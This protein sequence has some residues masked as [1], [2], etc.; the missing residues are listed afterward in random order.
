MKFVKKLK[1][2]V[3]VILNNQLLKLISILFLLD[4]WCILKAHQWSNPYNAYLF[5]PGLWSSEHQAAKYCS[6]YTASTGQTIV[7]KHGFELINGEYTGACNFSEIRLTK[8]AALQEADSSWWPR[9]L[10]MKGVYSL[11]KSILTK[12]N[13]RYQVSI[14]ETPEETP[15]EGLTL[16]PYI[17]DLQKLNFGQINDIQIVSQEYDK[18]CTGCPN[19]DIIL[20][21]VSRG[22][23]A[24][25]NFMA[26]EYL[27]KPQ[28]RVKAIVLEGCFDSFDNLT[29]LGYPLSF[30]TGYQYQGISPIS[31]VIVR[32]FTMISNYYQIPILFTTSLKDQRVP[33]KNTFNL[34]DAL[35]KAGVKDIYCLTLK[36]STHSAYL[37]DDLHN[38]ALI[39]EQ[40]V[41]AF[42]REYGLSHDPEL[43]QKG[44]SEFKNCK[45]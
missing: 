40:V 22:A 12:S 37:K 3:K 25:I 8:L 16:N 32:L 26:L 44:Y 24:T 41:H 18:I 19:Q 9:A 13:N 14:E 4:H 42:Y 35:K 5:A 1:I 29:C 38:D 17:L 20:F 15:N 30:F 7:G 23:A 31:P 45:I 11:G 28:K 36:N 34:C 33:A 39:Y 10:C 27:K 6:R 21:G 43:A 2:I